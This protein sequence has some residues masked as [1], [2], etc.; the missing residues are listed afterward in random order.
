MAYYCNL[1]GGW[2]LYLDHVGQQTVVTVAMSQAGQQQQAS[3]SATT[4][5]WTAP[6]QVYRLA[7][8]IVVM[9]ATHQ[10]EHYIQIQGTSMATLS[11]PPSLPNA[12]VLPLEQ[13]AQVP[14]AS[15]PS[16]GAMSPMTLNMGGMRMSMNPMEMRMGD[17]EMRM[18]S[19][20]AA[21]A[22]PPDPR[23]TRRFC[24]QCGAAVQ[25]SDRFCAS[26]GHRLEP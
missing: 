20:S 17:L 11:E 1:G 23:P 24:S 25:P 9:I 7:S 19:S 21:S 10:G 6:P 22:S 5:V 12:E 13:V 26:C 8:G 3:S 14:K 2:N 18:E 4:G 15:M 16:M